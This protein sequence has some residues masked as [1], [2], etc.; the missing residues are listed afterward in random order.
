MLLSMIT[1]VLEQERHWKR[2]IPWLPMQITIHVR[3]LNNTA[4]F[5]IFMHCHSKFILF[6]CFL[7]VTFFLSKTAVK[8][9][10]SLQFFHLSF[11]PEIIYNFLKCTFRWTYMYI[12]SFKFYIKS[13]HQKTNYHVNLI[14]PK[15]SV[16]LDHAAWWTLL[17][18]TRNEVN[19]ILNSPILY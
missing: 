8:A 15:S 6:L 2:S 16:Q 11:H 13:M 12:M 1:V 10:K 4:F 5:W 18:F 9:V 17:Y 7:S 14:L 3:W 19:I